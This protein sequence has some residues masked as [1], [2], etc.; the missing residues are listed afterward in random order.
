MQTFCQVFWKVYFYENTA[1][2]CLLSPS[3]GFATLFSETALP[4]GAHAAPWVTTGAAVCFL[5][6]ST[7]T[8]LDRWTANSAGISLCL[9][10]SGP[11]GRYSLGLKSIWLPHACWAGEKKGSWS[12]NQEQVILLSFGEKE[13]HCDAA[14]GWGD[15]SILGNS[16]WEAPRDYSKSQG[17]VSEFKWGTL[18]TFKN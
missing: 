3:W 15:A 10:P 16:K 12:L 13:G 11:G 17:Q 1:C 8:H 4:P 7:W 6:R 5:T 9:D 2:C 18:T 14:R